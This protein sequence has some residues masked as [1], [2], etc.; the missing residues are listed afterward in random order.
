MD[1]LTKISFQSWAAVNG[2][3]SVQSAE[4]ATSVYMFQYIVMFQDECQL[5]WKL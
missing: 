2:P 3:A 5:Y 1:G 4:Q